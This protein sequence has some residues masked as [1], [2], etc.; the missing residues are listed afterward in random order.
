MRA[1]FAIVCSASLVHARRMKQEGGATEWEMEN[2]RL[3]S[4]GELNDAELGLA[5]LKMAMRTPSVLSETA[6]ML[7]QPEGRLEMIKMMAN[8]EFRDQAKNAA[9]KVKV[10]GE[11][12]NFLNLEYYGQLSTAG[13]TSADP[14]N[15]QE[16]ASK[17][18]EA[19]AAF[20]APVVNRASS[21]KASA[22]M[23][24][25]DDLKSD[26]EELNP[27]IKY[28]DP[29]TLG[30]QE[31]WGQSN[32]ATI[33]F[34]RHA[35]IKHGRI[36]MAGFI[37]F[38]VHENG[39]HFPWKP[40]DGYEGLPAAGVWDALPLAARAQI[41]AAIGVFEILSET[42]YVLEAD[43]TSHYMRGGK[44]GYFPTFKTIP[45]PVPLNLWD[46]FGFTAK[47]SEA[48]KAKKLKIEVNNGRLA[49]IGLISVL[50]ASK[51]DQAVPVLNGLIKPY[52]GNIMAP[53]EPGVTFR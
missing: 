31:F 40:F 48:D 18:V 5:N 16:I 2:S 50:A 10:D 45:H 9:E 26:A 34:L 46:P 37:G 22:R 7:R 15:L 4:A 35:E 51:S 24:A 25:L 29:L 14:S 8:P 21:R 41:V 13:E 52:D 30:K 6:Q 36:A 42:Q 53:F 49:M 11:L 28:W 27:V 23:A 44:P 43:G 32:E 1:I 3:Y 19:A 12:P 47:L 39:I 38:C 20:N 33:G 17:A